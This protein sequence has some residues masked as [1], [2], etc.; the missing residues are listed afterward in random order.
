MAFSE[1][2]KNF[3]GMLK[4][5]IG[6]GDDIGPETDPFGFGEPEYP[7]Y[8]TEG[9][10]V[11]EPRENDPLEQI[12]KTNPVPK[13]SGFG[14]KRGNKVVPIQDSD[15]YKAS[16]VNIIEPRSFSESAQI[17]KKLKENKTVILHLDLLDKEQSQRTIDFVCGASH[18]LSG[19]VQKISDTVVVFAP[20]TV[21][22]SSESAALTSKFTESL[23]N[24]PL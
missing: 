24:K 20:N 12:Y 22:L 10:A 2:I 3:V 1:G 21:A 6:G 4:E 11:R 18:A 15:T 16:E 7:E 17:V 14:S 19:A 8:I 9:N 23:W 5:T 13:S